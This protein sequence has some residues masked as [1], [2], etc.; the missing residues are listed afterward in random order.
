MSFSTNSGVIVLPAALVKRF[1]TWRVESELGL[2][3]N[4]IAFE[5]ISELSSYN[6]ATNPEANLTD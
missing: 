3:K 6:D 4:V 1:A 5:L 2:E